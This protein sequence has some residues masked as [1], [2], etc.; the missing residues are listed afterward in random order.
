MDTTQTT[1]GNDMNNQNQNQ[2]QNPNSNSNSSNTK[3]QFLPT[4][5]EKLAAGVLLTVTPAI[6]FA[7]GRWIAPSCHCPMPQGESA[8]GHMA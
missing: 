3:F 5:K 4:W 6:G 1:N 2:N 8:E 7:V